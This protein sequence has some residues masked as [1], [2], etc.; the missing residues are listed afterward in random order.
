MHIHFGGGGGVMYM[1]EDIL[2]LL[3][4]LVINPGFAF[5]SCWK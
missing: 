1:R 2:K 5:P 3:T 4:V